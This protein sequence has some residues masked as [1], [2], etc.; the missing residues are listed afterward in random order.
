MPFQEASL[1]SRIHSAL[2][3]HQLQVLLKDEAVSW[4]GNQILNQ[5]IELKN[6]I[7]ENTLEG[8]RVAVSFPN[9]AVQVF[10]M[11]TVISTG[12]VPVM[13]SFSDLDGQCH[14][15]ITR[16]KVSLIILAPGLE[17][18]LKSETQTQ[19]IVLNRHAEILDQSLRKSRFSFIDLASPPPVGTGLILYTSGSTG[20]PKGIFIPETGILQTADYLISSMKLGRSTVSP[21]L[22]PIC[23]SMALNTQLFPTFFAGGLSSFVN[24]RLSITRI[25]RTILAEQGTFVS[26]ITEVLRTC[27]EEK[28][29]RKLAPALH[30][31]HVQLAGGMISLKT[32]EMAQELFPSAIIHKGYGLT[33]AIRVTMINSQEKNF[34]TSAVGKPLSFVQIQIRDQK[35][36]ANRV[37]TEPG[38]LGQVHVK[39]PNVLL[40][41]SDQKNS[42]IDDQGFLATGD[43]GYW[44]EDGQLCISGREDS[45]YKING[46]RVSGFE[47]ERIAIDASSLI[48]N[49]KCSLFEGARNDGKKLVLMVEVQ[50]DKQKKFVEDKLMEVH[51]K[52]WE[53]FKSLNH[54]PK[55]IIVVTKFPRTSNGKIDL[56][57]LFQMYSDTDKESISKI[58]QSNLQFY[59]MRSEENERVSV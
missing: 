46:L 28:N 50:Q 37:I 21:I 20:T 15:W 6:L 34:H 19:Y 27:W 9:W 33:E 57:K 45:L 7:S 25:Y 35:G 10:A 49:A 44:N 13:L 29:R 51:Q 4:T 56:K 14:E 59:Q 38:Q 16:S 36:H 47:I 22:L 53:Q 30:V 24:A 2:T 48:T 3:E 39:G 18:Q 11:F 54:F 31:Q 23:H 42:P 1:K 55:E 40:G 12:R 41:I 32:I 17:A 52:M 26:L 5:M 8:S 58:M 43:L